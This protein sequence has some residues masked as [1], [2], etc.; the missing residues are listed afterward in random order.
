M[1]IAGEEM[2]PKE[3][4]FHETNKDIGEVEKHVNK[5]MVLCSVL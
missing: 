2:T 5:A 3:A 1:T 4:T